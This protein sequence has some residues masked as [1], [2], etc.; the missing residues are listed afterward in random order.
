MDSLEDL[1]G[2]YETRQPKEIEAIKRYV[3]EQFNAEV[4]VGL[5]GDN[6]V[7]TAG[8]ASL[9]NALRLRTTQLQKACDTKKR[10]IFRIG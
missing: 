1:L 7:V 2:R 10:I 9:A 6:L 5:Q 8:S 4:G 3:L